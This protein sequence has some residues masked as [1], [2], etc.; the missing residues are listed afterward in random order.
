MD[1]IVERLISVAGAFFVLSLVVEKVAD[2]WK[3][4]KPD[5]RVKKL[6]ADEEKDRERRILARNIIVGIAVA[7]FLK[8]DSIQ[9]L[10]SG[11]PGQV[12]GWDNVLFFNNDRM[13]DLN[14]DNII[15][16]NA[17]RFSSAGEGIIKWIEMLL[18]IGLTGMALSFGSKFWHDLLGVLYEVK[19]VKSNTADKL[20]RE[21]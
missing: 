8:A 2:F 6:K 19:Q 12:L 7:L 5:I 3:L 4:H 20:L 16:F 18:G 11:E 21:T 13:A 1:T 14:N 15:Y 17:L 9:M 10:T